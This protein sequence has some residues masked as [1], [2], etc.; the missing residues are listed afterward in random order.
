MKNPLSLFNKNS[1]SNINLLKKK[2]Q[3][4]SLIDNKNR[5]GLKKEILFYSLSCRPIHDK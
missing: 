3:P 4:N 5:S 1:N 2:I